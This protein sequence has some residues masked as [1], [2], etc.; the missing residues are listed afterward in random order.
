MSPRAKKW[1]WV[2][3]TVLA[4]LGVAMVRLWAGA[5]TPETGRWVRAAGVLLALTG[6]FVITLG[7]RRRA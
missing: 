4:F 6:L 5:F 3:G 7:T 2:S 1:Y